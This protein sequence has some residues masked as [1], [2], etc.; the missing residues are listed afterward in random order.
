AVLKSQG[1]VEA[2]LVGFVE[3]GILQ[4]VLPLVLPA[5]ELRIGALPGRAHDEPEGARLR[6]ASRFEDQTPV[7][8]PL[9]AVVVFA[10]A[11]RWVERLDG[12]LRGSRIGSATLGP[13]R[14]A[15]AQT[16]PIRVQ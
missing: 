7:L 14:E 8:E 3:H 1:P 16:Q 10:P 13:R 9:S 12:L 4:Q 6:V 2:R 5:A 15:P 11:R